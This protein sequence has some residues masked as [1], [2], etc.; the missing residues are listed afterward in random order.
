MKYLYLNRRN[1]LIGLGTAAVF[2]FIFLDSLDFYAVALMMGPML[3]FNFAVG[4]MCYMED[5]AGTKQFLLSLPME[6][7]ELVLEKNIAAWLCLAA[8]MLAI[9]VMDILIGLLKYGRIYINAGTIL[10]MSAF[11]LIYYTVYL[12]LNYVFDYSRTQFVSCLLVVFMLGFYKFRKEIVQ[13]MAGDVTLIFAGA[14]IAAAVFNCLAMFY[15]AKWY[16]I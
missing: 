11:L 10:G 5:S 6:K 3:L 12:F 16:R 15:L 9:H 8:G 7:E 13:F 1:V 4:K 2:G 14:F